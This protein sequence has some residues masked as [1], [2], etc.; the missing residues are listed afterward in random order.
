[1]SWSRGHWISNWVHGASASTRC[2][3]GRAR[4]QQ[5]DGVL[6]CGIALFVGPSTSLLAAHDVTNAGELSGCVICGVVH[7]LNSMP[8]NYKSTCVHQAS[9]R[10]RRST[11]LFLCSGQMNCLKELLS[12]LRMAPTSVGW[13]DVLR[14]LIDVSDYNW[15]HG[16]HIC[17]L[18]HVA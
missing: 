4:P 12:L 1:M 6:E 9:T 17:A 10:Q 18:L 16:C 14:S 3:P 15:E 13:S 2:T 11:W 8:V 7:S 5:T